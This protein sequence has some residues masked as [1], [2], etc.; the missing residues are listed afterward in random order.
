MNI[1][2]LRRTI[3]TYQKDLTKVQGDRF[4]ERAMQIPE[5]GLFLTKRIKEIEDSIASPL[6]EEL[7][8][9]QTQDL[10]GNKRRRTNY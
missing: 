1:M 3:A 10:D 7:C 6:E 2:S 8:S 5:Y 9:L 4:S